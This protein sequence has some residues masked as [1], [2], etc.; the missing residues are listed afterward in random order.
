MAERH[1]GPDAGLARI[2]R[3]A[4]FRCQPAEVQDFHL[5]VSFAREAARRL[6]R[7]ASPFYGRTKSGPISPGEHAAG[8][9]KGRQRPLVTAMR[10]LLLSQIKELWPEV[11]Q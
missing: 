1:R 6:E 2:D 4:V 7:Y 8:L 3:A 5:K 10:P 11:V 9:W